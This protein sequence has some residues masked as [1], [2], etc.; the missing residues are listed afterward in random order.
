MT[1]L[2]LA[3]W[4]WLGRVLSS[5]PKMFVSSPA[6]FLA[7]LSARDIGC[8]GPPK[9]ILGIEFHRIHALIGSI[10]SFPSAKRNK[11]FVL[12]QE[13]FPESITPVNAQTGQSNLDTTVNITTRGFPE[14]SHSAADW[15][16][17]SLF[18]EDILDHSHGIRIALTA[19]R[20]K[21]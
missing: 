2:D 4:H 18:T 15:W 6:R 8:G 10:P 3:Q 17:A 13:K 21:Y 16:M 20:A 7:R 1:D 5:V 9:P 12:C 14:I 11:R 19:K